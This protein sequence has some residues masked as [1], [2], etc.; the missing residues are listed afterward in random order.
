MNE[1]SLQVDVNYTDEVGQTLLNWAAAFGSA[2]MVVYLCEKGA[3]VNKGQKSSSLHYAASF[4]R[5]DVS[6]R[7]RREEKEGLSQVTKM[8]LARGGNPDLRDE[9]G[10]T[11]LDK[12]R[13]EDSSFRTQSFH[14]ECCIR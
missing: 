2:E 5:P 1:L 6:E 11:A 13:R 3:D 7:E 10:K 14:F 9:D 12:V 8:L 4:G